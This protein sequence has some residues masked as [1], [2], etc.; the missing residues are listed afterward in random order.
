MSFTTVEN[1]FV[2]T[3]LMVRK[4]IADRLYLTKDERDGFP[5]DKAQRDRQGMKPS[6]KKIT[7][8]HGMQIIIHLV[9]DLTIQAKQPKGIKIR[10]GTQ[11]KYLQS[12]GK[13]V[14]K[15][16]KGHAFSVQIELVNLR[17][18][19]DENDLLSIKIQ[20]VNNNG[21]LT[22]WHLSDAFNWFK[23][24]MPNVGFSG[25]VQI[26]DGENMVSTWGASRKEK[27]DRD[28]FYVSASQ[29]NQDAADTEG[30]ALGMAK[31]NKERANMYRYWAQNLKG[32]AQFYDAVR[33]A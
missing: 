15:K 26:W 5:K 1:R 24:A 12:S 14:T 25:H 13:V 17:N 31:Y 23:R 2:G 30:K 29:L 6:V 32:A 16:N 27:V 33:T 11:T 19:K 18:K 22:K 9:T 3:E 10:E 28:F 8:L 21:A 20:L 7:W 4:L